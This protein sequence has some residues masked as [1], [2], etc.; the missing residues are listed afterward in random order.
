M[1]KISSNVSISIYFY[2]VLIIFG[3][4]I[5]CIPDCV[6]LLLKNDHYLSVEWI[7][8]EKKKKDV[9]H[10]I[11]HAVSA[12]ELTR[13]TIGRP[14]SF[15]CRCIVNVLYVFCFVC[16]FFFCLFVCECRP[17][18]LSGGVCCLSVGTQASNWSARDFWL[19]VVFALPCRWK[20]AFIVLFCV[21]G[22]L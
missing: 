5:F 21:L 3:C 7:F 20:I 6:Q 8:L 13:I 16:L 17:L 12:R 15:L 2:P 4:I 18:E 10:Y 11:E 19:S 9:H 22:L 14:V 1:I